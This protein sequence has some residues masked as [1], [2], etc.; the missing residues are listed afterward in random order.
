MIVLRDSSTRNGPTDGQTLLCFYA[1]G[2][3]RNSMIYVTTLQAI[4]G[5]RRLDVVRI[6]VPSAVPENHIG[7]RP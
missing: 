4:A 5:E 2:L 3:Q 7:V 1:T 6:I